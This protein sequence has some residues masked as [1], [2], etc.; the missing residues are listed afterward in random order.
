MPR[1]MRWRRRRRWW[2][3]T[4]KWHYPT[5]NDRVDL[6]QRPQGRICSSDPFDLEPALEQ[7]VLNLPLALKLGHLDELTNQVASR[8]LFHL[9]VLHPVATRPHDLAGVR[10]EEGAIVWVRFTR[11]TP[12]DPRRVIRM[13]EEKPIGVSLQ[14]QRL[15]APHTGHQGPGRRLTTRAGGLRRRPAAGAAPRPAGTVLRRSGPSR[16]CAAP[17]R[18][19]G[20]TRPPGERDPRRARCRDGPRRSARRRPRWARP[21]R[22]TSVPTRP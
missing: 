7:P 13:P 8:E 10:I 20:T 2:T 6:H 21:D 15:H 4:D 14:P 11:A 1:G 12:D 19:A 9:V 22:R 3:R 16:R 5:F 17:R 18:R